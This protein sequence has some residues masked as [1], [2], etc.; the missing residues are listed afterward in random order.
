MTKLALEKC[1]GK[2]M[3]GYTDL[4]HGMDCV[5]AWRDPQQL[6]LDLLL[7]PDEV[8]KLTYLA[9]QHFQ[10]LFDYYDEILKKQDQLSVT[11]MGIPSFGKMHIPSC[12]FGAMIS[13]ELFN[14]FCLPVI[15]DEVKPMTHNVFHLDGKGVAKH[16]DHILALP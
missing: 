15:Q 16:I 13:P 2:F 9:N 10:E 14:D 6:C 3:V 11:W 1:R 12:D 4:H 8:K 5:A 7:N